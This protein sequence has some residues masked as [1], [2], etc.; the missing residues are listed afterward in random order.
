MAD[1]TGSRSRGG[2]RKRTVLG[3]E[4][5]FGSL[6]EEARAF[7]DLLFGAVETDAVISLFLLPRAESIQL[8]AKDLEGAAHEAVQASLVEGTNVYFGCC[9]LKEVT[10]RRGTAGDTGV[11]PG[12]WADVDIAGPAHK[13]DALPPDRAAAWGL[14]QRM[15]PQPTL[16]VDS[17]WGFQAWWLFDR[18][19]RLK[20]DEGRAR[21]H[22]LVRGAQETLRRLAGEQGWTVDPTDDLAR[23]L[24]LPGTTNWKIEGDPRP[25]VVLPLGTEERYP[26]RMLLERWGSVV[27]DERSGPAPPFEERITAGHRTDS[28]ASLAGT[29]LRRRVV[30]SAALAAALEHNRLTCVPPLDEGK[31]R[32][33]VQGIYKRY[34]PGPV[35]TNGHKAIIHPG[36]V[37]RGSEVFA[38]EVPEIRTL[39]LLD[40]PGM[41][42]ENGSNLL[43]A[44]PKTGKTELIRHA[45]EEWVSAGRQV[46]YLTEESLWMWTTRLRYYKHPAEFWDG[47]TFCAAHGWSI[48]QVLDFLPESIDILVVDTLRSTCSYEEGKGD[49]GVVKVINPLIGAARD[50][51]A[52][53]LALYHARKMPGEGGRDISGHHSLYGAFDRAIQLRTVEGEGNERKRRLYVSGRMLAP[54]APTALDYRMLSDGTFEALDGRTVVGWEKTCDTC[55]ARFTA[56]RSTGRFCSDACRKQAFKLKRGDGA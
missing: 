21:A 12:V 28:I 18:P 3:V 40:R 1:S 46:V 45:L 7:L 19:A 20:D 53:L 13:S 22:R 55:H 9:L 38:L 43:Y 44:F 8:P 39:P 15:D 31:V 16:V 41:I 29:L 54:D 56:T 51:N 14:L 4:E 27:A 5:S 35:S 17:G 23:I 48:G 24:R 32:E 11:M 30:E 52:T 6:R 33:T 37:L 49:E 50:R 36:T 10:P 42:L 25:V 26:V 34:E 2:L 47:V